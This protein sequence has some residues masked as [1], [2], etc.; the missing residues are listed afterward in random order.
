VW[1]V[2]ECSPPLRGILVADG[3]GFMDRTLIYAE[4]TIY[5]GDFAP[6]TTDPCIVLAYVG[7]DFV[8]S[9]VIKF[10]RGAEDPS[11]TIPPVP[12]GAFSVAYI[13]LTVGMS[14]I[15]NSDITDYRDY[16]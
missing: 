8:T 1:L 14:V 11:P 9:G 2:T 16:V 13:T 5:T 7:S 6:P 3:Y 15:L 4:E 12:S 10:L